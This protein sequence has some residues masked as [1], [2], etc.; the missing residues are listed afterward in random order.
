[1]RHTS[2]FRAWR[3][4]MKL[5][6]NCVGGSDDLRGI[7]AC[8]RYLSVLLGYL[9]RYIARILGRMYIGHIWIVKRSSMTNVLRRHEIRRGRYR[10]VERTPKLP[11]SE[12]TLERLPCR[13]GATSRLAVETWHRLSRRGAGL[14]CS[15]TEAGLLNVNY[16]RISFHPSR[17]RSLQL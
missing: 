9:S 14:H 11:R 15:G 6:N 7:L 2:N 12:R 3:E 8:Y 16:L 10:G 17:R 5:F 4:P 13:G 1:M